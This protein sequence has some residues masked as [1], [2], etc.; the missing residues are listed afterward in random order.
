[1]KKIASAVIAGARI[2]DARQIVRDLSI[3]V[4]L[5]IRL[6]ANGRSFAAQNCRRTTASHFASQ[7]VCAPVAQ[8]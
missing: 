8:R 4:V 1:M 2:Y 7:N 5:P 3:G 6:Q